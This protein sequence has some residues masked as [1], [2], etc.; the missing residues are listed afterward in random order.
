MDSEHF[1][2]MNSNFNKNNINKIYITA[3][4]DHFIL[5]KTNLDKVNINKVLS[6]KME[7][8]KK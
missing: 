6:S 2:L 3:S 5:T 7:N 8:G 1:S 4:E